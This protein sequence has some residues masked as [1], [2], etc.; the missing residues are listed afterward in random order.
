M[1]K[2]IKMIS[3][4]NKTNATSEPVIVDLHPDRPEFRGFQIGQ[5]PVSFP[6]D[7]TFAEI[8][9]AGGVVS[10][11]SEAHTVLDDMFLVSGFILPSAPYETG[12]KGG[13]RV[14][15]KSK[16]WEKDE[17]MADERFLMCNLKGMALS[18]KVC[19]V[20]S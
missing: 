2:A 19:L 11:S 5:N 8:E 7:P 3:E 18:G 10:K 12:L 17:E 6:A 14:Q 9:D 4:A 16:G 15:D 13:I 20:T 1:L